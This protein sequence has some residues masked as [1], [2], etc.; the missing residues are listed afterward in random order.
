M[1]KVS[2]RELV[3]KDA[4]GVCRKQIWKSLEIHPKEFSL[5]YED[6][7]GPLKGF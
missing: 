1:G 6:K 7:E 2:T 5:Y 4:K 3:E